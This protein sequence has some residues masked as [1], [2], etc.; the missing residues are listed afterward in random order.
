M[1]L[2]WIIARSRRVGV[3]RR[4][5]G[6]SV[7]RFL[8]RIGGMILYKSNESDELKKNGGWGG[9]LF[10]KI[11]LLNFDYEGKIEGLRWKPYVSGCEMALMAGSPPYAISSYERE[12][13][14]IAT[15]AVKD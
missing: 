13:E 1:D 3:T 11:G 12:A 5:G 14:R 9:G 2:A 6:L 10:S 15:E 8:D 7:P 4:A